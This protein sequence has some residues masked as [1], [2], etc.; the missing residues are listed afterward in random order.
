MKPHDSFLVILKVLIGL[1]SIFGWKNQST[2]RPQQSS[3]PAAPDL[4]IPFPRKHIGLKTNSFVSH[5]ND[6][7]TLSIHGNNNTG[8]EQDLIKW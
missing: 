5:M 2:S 1:Q 3:I 4:P 7:S 8:V 6:N